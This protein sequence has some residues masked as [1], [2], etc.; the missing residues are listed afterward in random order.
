[1]LWKTTSCL[2]DFLILVLRLP[3]TVEDAIKAKLT[4]EQRMLSYRFRLARE[5]DEKQRRII[6]AEGV[7]EFEKISG[8]SMLRWRGIEATETLA[9]SP[10]SKIIL[11]G[12]GAGQLPVVLNS[13]VGFS[14]AASAAAHSPSAQSA[15]KSPVLPGT[16][17]PGLPAPVPPQSALVP[18]LPL[19]RARPGTNE[20]P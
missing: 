15:P 5:R 18:P 1:M 7:R 20:A 9:A 17:P 19:R 12:T 13:D 14:G 2:T 10:N 3:L 6:E 16:A 8:L 11:M 4:E